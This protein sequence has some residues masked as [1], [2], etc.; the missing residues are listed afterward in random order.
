MNQFDRITTDPTVMK[1]RPCIRGQK[2]T[3][4]KIVSLIELG[5]ERSE[6]LK[7]YPWLEPEDIKQ[8]L[9]YAAMHQGE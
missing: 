1:G 5:H 6:I 8:A 3:V 9:K 7:L 2:L 4:G